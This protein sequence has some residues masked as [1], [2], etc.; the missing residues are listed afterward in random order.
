[1][2]YDF[3]TYVDRH[4]TSCF[5]WEFE[6]YSDPDMIPLWVADMDFKSPPEVIEA[7]KK[8]VDHGIFGYT[9]PPKVLVEVVVDRLAARYKWNVD[10]EWIVWL[11]GIVSGINI[12]CR[13]FARTNDEVLTATPV[14]Y[15]FISAPANHNQQI[16][17][18]L[19]RKVGERWTFDFEA[20]EKSITDKTKIFL[21]CNPHNPVGTV[22]R[23]DELLKLANICDKHDI[24]ICSDEIHCDVLLDDEVKHIPIASLDEEVSK[25]II[26]LM[27]PTKT[28]NLAGLSCSFAVISDKRLRAKFQMA[29]NGLVPFVN[30][31]GYTASLA[32]YRDGNDWLVSLLD[33]LRGNA[34]FLEDFVKKIPGFKMSRPEATYLAW[35]DIRDSKI[36]DPI[37]YFDSIGVGFSD[38]KVFGS[39]GFIRLNFGCPRFLLKEAMTRV[40]SAVLCR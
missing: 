24:I 18:V 38:G 15:P 39:P 2:D 37:K 8:R 10:P 36:I 29:Q 22:Y 40:K 35:I 5:K 16:V 20:I 3:D 4:K 21:L 34:D 1:M 31:F 19:L 30:L 11:P 32:A 14:Y 25:R 33:Y 27:A 28:F 7:L 26:T 13:A 12:T 17:E 6:K 9:F 23:R